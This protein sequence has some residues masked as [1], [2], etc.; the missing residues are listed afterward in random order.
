MLGTRTVVDTIA[1]IVIIRDSTGICPNMSTR[2]P[3]CDGNTINVGRVGVSNISSHLSETISGVVLV[4]PSLSADLAVADAVNRVCNTRASWSCASSTQLGRCVDLSERGRTAGSR[5]S[6]VEVGHSHPPS[7]AAMLGIQITEYLLDDVLCLS[8]YMPDG[9][10]GLQS[11]IS[12]QLIAG[13]CGAL[14]SVGEQWDSLRALACLSIHSVRDCC[15]SSL[16][17]CLSSLASL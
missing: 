1:E 12:L 8:Q 15:S 3:I 2:A 17:S 16:M 9:A 7:G 4:A 10:S 14:P 6:H 5:F 11:T 13:V